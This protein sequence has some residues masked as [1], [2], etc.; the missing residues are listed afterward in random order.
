MPTNT[1]SELASLWGDYTIKSGQLTELG[2]GAGVRYNGISYADTGQF[3]GGSVLCGWRRRHPLYVKNWRFQLNVTNIADNIYVGSCSDADSMLLRRST[4]RGGK[5]G[6][7]MVGCLPALRPGGDAVKARSVR[8]WTAV[9]K[10]TSLVSTVFLLKKSD[11]RSN[12]R[13]ATFALFSCPARRSRFREDGFIR[14]VSRNIHPRDEAIL[15]LHEAP[16]K[17]RPDLIPRCLGLMDFIY[18]GSL[19]S[20]AYGV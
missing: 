7:Q 13:S 14:A 6:L 10:W 4:P 16:P 17:R 11:R 2:F 20:I 18:H 12:C 8:I 19:S 5:R 15:P 1:P 3:A 9:H